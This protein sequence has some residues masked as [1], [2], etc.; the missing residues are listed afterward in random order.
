MFYNSGQVFSGLLKQLSYTL[1][2]EDHKNIWIF[3]K[4][5]HSTIV[6]VEGG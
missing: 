4:A 1:L 5:M 2:F 6:M 3:Q